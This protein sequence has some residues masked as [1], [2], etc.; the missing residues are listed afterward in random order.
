ML[1]FTGSKKAVQNE[2]FELLTVGK[3]AKMAEIRN[4]QNFY[5]ISKKK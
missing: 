4:S 1:R 2:H 3:T 5:A